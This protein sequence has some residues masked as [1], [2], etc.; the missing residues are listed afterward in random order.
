MFYNESINDLFVAFRSL[1]L[2]FNVLRLDF[3]GGPD[4]LDI[5]FFLSSQ[6]YFVSDAHVIFLGGE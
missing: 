2:G 4:T 5:E 6:F 1:F 3:H